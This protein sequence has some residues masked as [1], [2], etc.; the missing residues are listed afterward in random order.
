MG[1]QLFRIETV[2]NEMNKNDKYTI[3]QQ[4]FAI[5]K[6]KYLNFYRKCVLSLPV[7]IQKAAKQQLTVLGEPENDA[8]SQVNILDFM[9]HA[10]KLQQSLSFLYS[11]FDFNTI[12]TSK[13]NYKSRVECMSREESLE[14]LYDICVVVMYQITIIQLMARDDYDYGSLTKENMVLFVIATCGQGQL[15]AN[16]MELYKTLN[17]MS[18]DNT[19][20]EFGGTLENTRMTVFRMGDSHYLYFNEAAKLYES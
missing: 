7:S 12:T 11:L 15:P 3:V 9:F 5:L 8:A 6:L 17:D 4:T 13:K 16:C 2:V 10:S 20:S 18:S 14:Y 19:E 1:T